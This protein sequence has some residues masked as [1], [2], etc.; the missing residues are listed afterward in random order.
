MAQNTALQELIK[1]MD[2]NKSHCTYGTI[3]GK[4]IELL[5]KERQDIIDAAH[6]GYMKAAE[7]NMNWTSEDYFNQQFKTTKK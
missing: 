2:D 7:C 3:R 5:P 1:W 4:A 6:S